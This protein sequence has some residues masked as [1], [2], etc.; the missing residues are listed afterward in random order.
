M[1]RSITSIPQLYRNV[2]RWTE[3]V[4]VLSKYGLADWLSRF[5]LDFVKDALRAPDGEALARLTQSARIRLAFTEL[6]PTFIKFGQLLSTRPDLTGPDLAEELSLLQD[7]TPADDFKLVKELIE[8]EQGASSRRNFQPFRRSTNCV[9]VDWP[10]SLRDA[11]ARNG[12]RD[13][14][15]RW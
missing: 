6:G 14:G 8:A 13:P 2:R 9:S 4:S 12:R 7:G 5:N 3:I 1:K 11:Q 15:S 10:G